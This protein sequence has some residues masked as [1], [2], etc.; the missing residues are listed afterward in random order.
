MK[1]PTTYHGV[2]ILITAVGVSVRPEI[3][4]A[5]ITLGSAFSGLILIITKEETK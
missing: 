2:N 3:M 1:E 5:I 4:N